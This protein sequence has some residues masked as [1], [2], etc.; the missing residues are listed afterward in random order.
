MRRI[1][2]TLLMGVAAGH[3]L[4]EGE[5]PPPLSAIDWLSSSVAT[6]PATPVA[7]P[8]ELFAKE[9]AE[10]TVVPLDSLRPDEAGLIPP[11]RLGLD[12]ELWGRSSARDL[13]KALDA[14]TPGAAPS[15]QEFLVDLLSA[16]FSPPVDAASDQSWFLARVDKLLD[17]GRLDHA[18]ALLELAGPS[19]PHRFRRWFDIAVLSGAEDAACEMLEATPGLSPT[20]PARIFCLARGGEWDVAALTLGNAEALGILGDAEE[21]LFRHFL[22]PEMFEG[23]PLPPFTPPTTPLLYAIFEAVGERPP[24]LGLPLAFAHADISE[25]VGWKTRLRA[26][27]RLAAAG[28]MR[29]E[30]LAA[31]MRKHGPAASGGVWE[32]VSAIVP[33]LDEIDAGKIRHETLAGAWTAAREGGYRAALAE[34]LLPALDGLD[35]GGP[36]DRAAFEAAVLRDAPDAARRFASDD[37]DAVI[38]AV[39]TEAFESAPTKTALE[40]AVVQGLVEREL[41]ESAALLIEDARAGEALLEA[42]RRLSPQAGG[43]PAAVRGALA[44]LAHLGA[45]DA[46][47]RI[48][49]ELLLGEGEA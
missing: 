46:A 48:G 34:L 45:V 36:G 1:E 16:R 25:R 22:D 20:Y 43:D 24:T 21:V 30:E 11:R 40:R 12:P 19:E 10:V 18:R 4:A 8:R 15:A 5:L 13:A 42:M 38:L 26:A 3:A 31:M 6:D 39:L 44:T 37:H 28:A 35:P 49:A 23:E 41:P 14:F 9:P 33:L 32:R 17:M 47:R 27:E 29:G 2:L 7:P